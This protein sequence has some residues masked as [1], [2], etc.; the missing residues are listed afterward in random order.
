[1]WS[2]LTRRCEWRQVCIG[3]LSQNC[4]LTHPVWLSSKQCESKCPHSA[5][6]RWGEKA[7]SSSQSLPYTIYIVTVWNLINRFC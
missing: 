1:M 3:R 4:S 7:D 5:I 2:S 6:W